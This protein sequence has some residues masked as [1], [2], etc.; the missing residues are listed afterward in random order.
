MSR[1]YVNENRAEIAS[2]KEILFIF[3]IFTFILYILYPGDMQ[4]KQVLA[5]KSNYALTTIYLKDMLRLEP[6]NRDLLFATLRVSLKSGN[7]DLSKNL[8]SILEEVSDT[9]EKKELYL[10]KFKLL[11]KEKSNTQNQ[12]EITK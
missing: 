7:I 6:K 12:Q 10:Y 5:E 11:E 1:F 3:A 8:I 9:E 2:N 4:R